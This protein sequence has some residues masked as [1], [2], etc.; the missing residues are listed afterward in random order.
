[1]EP[2]RPPVALPSAWGAIVTGRGKTAQFGSSTLRSD[3]G[4]AAGARA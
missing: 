1:M 3:A 4:N 2:G